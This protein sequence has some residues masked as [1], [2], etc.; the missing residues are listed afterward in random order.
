MYK[1]TEHLL[2]SL[3]DR[4][5]PDTLREQVPTDLQTES[6]YKSACALQHC[7]NWWIVK[8]F[9]DQCY[10][11]NRIAR[12][13]ITSDQIQARDA[14]GELCVVDETLP[15]WHMPACLTEDARG[16]LVFWDELTPGLYDLTVEPACST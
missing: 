3:N 6:L 9:C 10:G 2:N 12:C 5:V 4:G 1:E 7:V 8:R 14:Q 15:F 13:L 16:E 11:T